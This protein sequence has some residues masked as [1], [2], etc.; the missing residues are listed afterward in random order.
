M[1][2]AERITANNEELR[3]CIELIENLPEADSG[4]P[5]N[6]TDVLDTQ[7]SKLNELL[8]ILDG[9]AA[10]GGEVVEAVIQSLT[11]TENGTYNAPSGVDGYNP[12]K[13]NVPIPDGYV[14]PSGTKSITSNGT[15]DVSSYASVNVDVPT[16]SGGGVTLEGIPEGYAKVDYLQFSG[17][18]Y[19][20]TGLYA[21]INTKIRVLFT[22]E[23]SSAEYL[24]GCASSG[25]TASFTA[26]LS[27]G[28]GWRFGSKST[29]R[30]LSVATNI[31]HTAVVQKTGVIS[32]G[33]TNAFS[34]VTDFT[35]PHAVT[36]GGATQTGGGRDAQFTGKLLL[37]EWWQDSELVQKIVPVVSADGVYKPWD[38]VTQSFPEFDAP[39]PFGG[40]IL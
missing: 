37:W 34:S 40:G 5:E 23:S 6:L 35:T 15:H 19:I 1:T 2:N 20:D 16:E 14:K 22:R 3:K 17:V 11:V 38:M 31:I 12:V 9:K 13:V 30:S 25:N 39:T 24:Y 8:D 32:A 33:G 28:G 4:E 29:S 18:Q 36:L 27:S 21:D 26:Y 7:E 10:G